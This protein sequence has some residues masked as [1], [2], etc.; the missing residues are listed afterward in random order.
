MNRFGDARQHGNVLIRPD[1][2]FDEWTDLGGG[3][4]FRL[5]R[6]NDAPPALRFHG[7]HGC[8]RR[9]IAIPHAVTMRHL[10]KPVLRGD[11][12]DF[13]RFEKNIVAPVARHQRKTP[14]ALL[15]PIPSLIFIRV[16]LNLLKQEA[17]SAM[18]PPKEKADAPS[19]CPP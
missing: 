8:E 15:T 1:P 4:D 17:G 13:H 16:A 2:Q 14:L 6:A 11:R 3:M 19:P 5:L 12:A 9:G 18:I 10:K 7:P